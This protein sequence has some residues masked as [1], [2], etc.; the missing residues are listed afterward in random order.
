[1][2]CSFY[3]MFGF[4][5]IL[6]FLEFHG[7][8]EFTLKHGN[9][10]LL[11]SSNMLYDYGD[12]ANKEVPIVKLRH[13]DNHMFT[14][15][16]VPAQRVNDTEIKINLTAGVFTERSVHIKCSPAMVCNNFASVSVSGSITERI[17]YDATEEFIFQRSTVQDLHVDMDA[18]TVLKKMSSTFNTV[19]PGATMELNA[20]SRNKG[21]Y[22]TEEFDAFMQK[23]Q[24]VLKL[25]S[26]YKELTPK[27]YH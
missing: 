17:Q 21:F 27:R 22:C 24:T 8:K 20:F 2:N 13:G 1:M 4:F 18:L 16:Q 23:V 11:K 3:Q 9:F 7:V 6:M 19:M 10:E 5:E 26:T 14:F 15:T 25:T 12:I